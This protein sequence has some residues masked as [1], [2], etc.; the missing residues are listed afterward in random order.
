MVDANLIPPA[1]EAA[2]QGMYNISIYSF[3]LVCVYVIVVVCELDSTPNL[4]SPS[5]SFYFLFFFFFL[6][7]FPMNSFF[8]FYS[9]AA[10]YNIPVW[11][12]PV[13]VAKSTRITSVVNNVSEFFSHVY[14]SLQN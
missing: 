3:F 6:F 4:P 8:F 2:C 7:P 10:E 14:H 5:S 12:E 1:L 11:F 13:S 9:V